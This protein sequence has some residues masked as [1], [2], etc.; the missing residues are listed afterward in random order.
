MTGAPAPRVSPGRASGHG[1][2]RAWTVPVPWGGCAGFCV[3]A[4]VGGLLRGGTPL[5]VPGAQLLAGVVEGAILGPPRARV[6]RQRLDGFSGARRV[7]GTASAAAGAWFLGMPP[8]AFRE[9]VSTWPTLLTVIAAMVLGT[10]VP[11]GVRLAPWSEL[12][13][14][15]PRAARWIPIAVAGWGAGQNV[16]LARPIPLP[17]PG[18]APAPVVA[19]GS[20]AVGSW[21]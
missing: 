6:L 3:P 1:L 9:Q 8:S 5:L 21:R 19:V 2:V 18:Q 12:R 13:R 15:R 11:G 17:R 14:H 4:L 20:P 7:V 10:W 16:F